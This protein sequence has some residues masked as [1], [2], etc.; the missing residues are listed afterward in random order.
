M[1]QTQIHSVLLAYCPLLRALSACFNSSDK[2]MVSVAT[3]Q[4]EYLLYMSN[5][6]VWNVTRCSQHNT[7]SLI[8][9]LAIPESM[10]ALIQADCMQM[11]MLTVD[12][13]DRES[14]NNVN[15]Q[16]VHHQLFHTS[17]HTILQSLKPSMSK[18]EIVCFADG[19][20]CRAIY[21]LGPYI[22]D[23]PKQ[24]LLTCTVQG[25]CA[26]SVLAVM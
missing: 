14:Q 3:G 7:V 17:L 2:T 5:G 13:A 9:F 21:G 26:K 8:P 18:P 12:I 20:F 25:W 22:A 16:K 1:V 10:Y 15:S 23:Y 11:L 24:V 6:L 19:H 4:N